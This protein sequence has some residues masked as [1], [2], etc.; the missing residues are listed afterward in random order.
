[1]RSL[2]GRGALGGGAID[3]LFRALA[4][5]ARDEGAR[6]RRTGLQSL[7]M[8]GSGDVRLF[9]IEAAVPSFQRG[10]TCRTTLPAKSRRRLIRNKARRMS[11]TQV[12]LLGP[13]NS[14]DRASISSVV[15]T[16][17]II[18]TRLGAGSDRD[19]PPVTATATTGGVEGGGPEITLA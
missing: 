5:V 6:S 1:M 17:I 15:P 14:T 9:A 19:A 10:R 18:L 4:R 11:A 2:S 16:C 8:Q 7:V 12:A 3:C 13:L